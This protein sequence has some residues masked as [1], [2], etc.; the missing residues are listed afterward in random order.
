MSKPHLSDKSE[1]PESGQI[2]LCPHR[3]LK[4]HE[5]RKYLQTIAPIPNPDVTVHISPCPRWSCRAWV[6]HQVTHVPV[7]PDESTTKSHL[8]LPKR[9]DFTLST[10]FRLCKIEIGNADAH[11]VASHRF[12]P[13]RVKHALSKLNIPACNHVSLSDR[14]VRDHFQPDC[15]LLK[16]LDRRYRPCICSTSSWPSPVRHSKRCLKCRDQN[17]FTLI[18]FQ[19]Q[20]SENLGRKYLEL[21]LTLQRHLG[22]LP[23]GPSEA[24]WTCHALNVHQLDLLPLVAQEWLAVVAQ[25]ARSARL[26]GD[27]GTPS[28]YNQFRNFLRFA[29]F[30]RKAF[31]CVEDEELLDDC[32]TRK[33]R[34]YHLTPEI[35]LKQKD[36]PGKHESGEETLQKHSLPEE[37]APPP[38]TEAVYDDGRT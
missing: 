37:Q 3:S 24:G 34:K 1:L 30:Q 13:E 31:A 28:I 27:P 21:C 4:H 2:W 22:S 16:T 6:Q 23:H 20:E 18:A 25:Q 14:F 35:V 29:L 10:L 7:V 8:S 11:V 33:E 38:Y 17:S 9:S 32:K 19:A 15:L 12:T 36:P 5:A 26:E